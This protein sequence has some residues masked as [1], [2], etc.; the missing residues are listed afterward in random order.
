MAVIIVKTQTELDALQRL[1]SKTKINKKYN[2]WE[3]TGTLDSNGYGRLR[4][5]S[6]SAAHRVSY[7]LLKG[8]IKNGLDVSHDC[9][10]P[11]CVNPG[12][13][14]LLSRSDNLK[15]SVKRGRIKAGV[16]NK[17]SSITKD[18]LIEMKRLY[19]NGWSFAELAR[20]FNINKETSRRYLLKIKSG[21]F[22]V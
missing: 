20:K 8:K 22:K 18:Q 15:D 16:E 5:H 6:E 11:R 14:R 3:F 12:H 19:K 7:I 10:N 1:I 9:D 2:C 13:L 4:F 17:N 21:Q